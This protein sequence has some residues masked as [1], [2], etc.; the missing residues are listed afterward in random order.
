MSDVVGAGGVRLLRV[1]M[2]RQEHAG[3]SSDVLPG[4]GL[5][6]CGA[7]VGE[8]SHAAVASE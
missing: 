5:L 7:Y 8:S 2:E 1:E 4:I 3:R 6:K